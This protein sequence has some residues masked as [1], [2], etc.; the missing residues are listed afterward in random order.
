MTKDTK[1]DSLK[2]SI[3]QFVNELEFLDRIPNRTT[4]SKEKLKDLSDKFGK[5]I[6]TPSVLSEIMGD[7][8]FDEILNKT[9]HDEKTEGIK[10]FS[11]FTDVNSQDVADKTYSLLREI[12]KE[13]TFIF[14]FPL[15]EADIPNVKLT[16]NIELLKVDKK[17]IEEY[18]KKESG[19]AATLSSLAF[20][21]QDRR[22]QLKEK[23][24]LLRI[25]G[26]GYVGKYGKVKV[27][28]VDPLYVYKVILGIYVTLG[29]L[30]RKKTFSSL[31]FPFDFNYSVFEDKNKLLRTLT[32]STED[33]QYISR[34]EFNESKFI[35]S[36]TEKLLKKT[37]TEFQVANS[38]ISNLFTPIKFAKGKTDDTVIRRQ[39]MI[40]NGTYWYYESLK[41]NQDYT[42][43]I[44]LTTAFDSLL[45]SR[46]AEES[47]E[48][49]AEIISSVISKNILESDA[50]FKLIVDLYELRNKIVHGEK[51]ISSL[52]KYDDFEES[53]TQTIVG[54]GLLYLSNFLFN[55]VYFID[56][57][58]SLVNKRLGTFKK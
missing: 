54:M 2:T 32:E 57:G 16:H 22:P 8:A 29:I 23:E 25:I 13:Y 15:I 12:P 37:Q 48:H 6:I 20:S 34:M 21:I 47:K 3:K 50:I 31:G 24:L 39:R 56:R 46:K 5:N 1:E 26:K 53:Q 18:S 52:E 42:R 10:K 19:E 30:K 33:A 4:L 45:S 7:F 43:A 36:E 17:I 38:I 9:K 27:N 55:R 35:L 58:L 41:T 40:K 49:K 14:R 51:E 28:V 44:Y 11:Q